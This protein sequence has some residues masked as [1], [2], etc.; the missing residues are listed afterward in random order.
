MCASRA[1]WVVDREARNSGVM[2]GGV[3]GMMAASD[4]EE[5]NGANGARG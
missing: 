3:V 1:G 5:D 2:G 4:S